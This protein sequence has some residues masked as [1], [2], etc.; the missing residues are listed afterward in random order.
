MAVIE[1]TVD[2][3]INTP[4]QLRLQLIAVLFFVAEEI[5]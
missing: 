1:T 4:Y 5:D 3:S 2:C